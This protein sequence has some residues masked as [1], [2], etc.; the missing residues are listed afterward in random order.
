MLRRFLFL[1]LAVPLLAL[2][3]PLVEGASRP[4]VVAPKSTTL[5]P[6]VLTTSESA[7]A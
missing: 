1:L 4:S 6:L 7:A 3:Q 5:A 2:A